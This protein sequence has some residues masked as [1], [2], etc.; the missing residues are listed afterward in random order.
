MIEVLEQIAGG[1]RVLDT[2]VS[3][4]RVRGVLEDPAHVDGE[5]L[6]TEVVVNATA[7]VVSIGYC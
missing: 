3:F 2:L 6:P 5:L 1:A 4:D 7:L